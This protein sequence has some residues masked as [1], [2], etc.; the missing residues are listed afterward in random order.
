MK[1]KKLVLGFTGLISCG[2]DTASDYFA[3][4]HNTKQVKFSASMKDIMDRVY[5]EPVRKNYQIISRVLREAFGQ[6]LFSK[7]VAK[8]VKNADVDLVI[9][10]GIRRIPDIDYLKE[11]EGF[12]LIAVEV[13]AKTRYERLNKRNEKPGD[14]TKTWEEFQKDDMAETEITIPEIMAQADVTID[15]NGTLEEFY[16]KLD[17][18]VK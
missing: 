9:V 13:D 16:K 6:D 11:I 8:D 15:N 1:N 17:E 3:E 5:I 18:L 7:V 10:D 2:K 4:K 12:K 14:T